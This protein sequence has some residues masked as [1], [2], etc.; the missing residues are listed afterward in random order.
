VPTIVDRRTSELKGFSLR[1]GL[2]SKGM[3]FL[4]AESPVRN[5]L[6]AANEP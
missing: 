2:K 5:L 6:F 1:I 4:L 3:S